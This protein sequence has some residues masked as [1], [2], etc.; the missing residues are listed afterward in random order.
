MRAWC[1]ASNGTSV[2][3]VVATTRMYC[4]V[5]LMHYGLNELVG[6]LQLRLALIKW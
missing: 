1:Y 6:I 2:I 4:F 5:F 3:S